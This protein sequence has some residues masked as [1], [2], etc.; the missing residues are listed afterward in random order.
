MKKILEGKNI[1]KTFI[2]GKF[3]NEVL[4]NLNVSINEG[5]ITVLL[6][7]SGSGKTTLLNIISGLDRATSG[8]VI[9][10]GV[11]IE[12]LN[13]KDLTKFRRENISF[14]FQQYNLVK[15]LTVYE[16]VKLTAELVQN[17]A[18]I[19]QTLKEVGL[20]DY[21]D[22]YPH[23]LSG[24]MQQ[25]VAIARAL[26]KSPKIMFCDEPTGALDEKSGRAVLKLLG[27][28]NKKG[29]TLFMI[30]HNPNIAKMAHQVIHIKNGAIDS[31]IR[32]DKILDA[33][34]I[35]WG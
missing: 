9:V 26:V 7:T 5:E 6:G 22:A 1:N 29:S 3:T 27:D 17:E 15:D 14:I 31:V 32:N 34:E 19:E 10:N 13:E 4:K 23:Q 33:Y 24:G 28:I 20:E 8:E 25:R 35:E 30:T 2:N 16:N 18:I 21:M 11:N 12:N